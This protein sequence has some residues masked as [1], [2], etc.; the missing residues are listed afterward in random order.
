MRL[1]HNIHLSIISRQEDEREALLLALKEWLG[2][3]LKHTTRQNLKHAGLDPLYTSRTTITRQPEIKTV[4]KRFQELNAE[5]LQ[6]LS[7]EALHRLD[8]H[9]NFFFR[10]DKQS[11]LEGQ[12]RITSR[13]NSVQVRITLS[14][15]PKTMDNAVQT[16]RKL[17]EPGDRDNIS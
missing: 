6:T 5:D 10:L 14:A 8:E 17:L 4:I 15:H 11:I 7:R 2:T 1:A 13:G 3:P 9:N 12:P 16:I